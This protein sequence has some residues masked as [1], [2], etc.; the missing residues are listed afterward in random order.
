MSVVRLLVYRRNFFVGIRHILSVFDLG[1]IF[2]GMQHR[3]TRARHD[4][5]ITPYFKR[6]SA[7]HHPPLVVRGIPKVTPAVPLIEAARA[8]EPPQ[9]SRGSQPLHD[10]ISLMNIQSLLEQLVSQREHAPS[11][12]PAPAPAPTPTPAQ[13]PSEPPPPQDSLGANLPDLLD[14]LVAS[15]SVEIPPAEAVTKSEEPAKKAAAP[16]KKRGPAKKP[17]PLK[18]TVDLIVP[19]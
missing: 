15:R 1:F 18:K 13:R 3:Q 10:E 5:G 6:R 11:P 4:H 14:Q 8:P 12:A 16:K 7:A 17:P 2:F 19:E 9:R